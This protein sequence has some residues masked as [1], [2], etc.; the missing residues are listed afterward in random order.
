MN[1]MDETNN[2]FGKGS[3]TLA[4]ARGKHHYRI[5][6]GHSSRIDTSYVA[7]APVVRA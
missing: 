7:M 1:V 5:K 6:R 4:A 2:R 3:I